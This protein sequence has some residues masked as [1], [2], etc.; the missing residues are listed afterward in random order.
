MVGVGINGL[1]CGVVA[2]MH[3]LCCLAFGLVW[4]LNKLNYAKTLNLYP[5]QW[6]YIK[7]TGAPIGGSSVGI[8]TRPI[9]LAWRLVLAKRCIT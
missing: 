2:V 4:L 1:K 5:Y 7:S 3:C 9:N 8:S 6:I